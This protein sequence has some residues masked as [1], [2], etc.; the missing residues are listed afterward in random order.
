MT[1]HERWEK[2]NWFL[3]L[4]GYFAAGYLACN[5]FNAQRG[6]YYD[7]SLGF[8][9]SI[10]FVPAFILGYLCVYGSM[11]YM[12]IITNEITIWR[13]TAV[14]IV[15]M[16]TVAFI[17]FLIFPVKMV[18]R[19]EIA[20][21]GGDGIVDWLTRFYFVIDNPYNAFPSLHVAY[22]TICTLLVWRTHPIARWV[23][24]IMTL[25]TAVSVVLVKQHYIADIAGGLIVA[26]VCFVVVSKTEAWWGSLFKGSKGEAQKSQESTF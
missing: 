6:V 14:S 18:L 21:V 7:I 23:I 20:A 11:I 22:P 9:S 13:R 16:T 26:S 15:L 17:M 5:W 24:A 10:P 19:P 4:V 1:S 2:R 12:Y 8:E 3:F 25:I